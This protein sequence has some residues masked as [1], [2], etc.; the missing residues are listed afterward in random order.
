[1]QQRVQYFCVCEGDQERRY[2]KHLASLLK[3]VTF[4]AVQGRPEKVL[5]TTVSYDRVI[6]FDHD[7]QDGEFRKA[8]EICANEEKRWNSNSK[9]QDFIHCYPAYSNLNFDL[10]LILHSED[11]T[12]AVTDNKAYQKDV[13]R[14]FELHRDADI[15]SEASM[16]KIL[17]RI[18]LMDVKN[19]I[20]RA[21]AIR[22]KKVHGD[23]KRLSGHICYD[24]PD[25]SIHEFLKTVFEECG[26]SL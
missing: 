6:F 7:G 18:T 14:I 25:F 15:K 19:A 20:R 8:F 5:K 3:G 22:G 23:E 17:S 21:E 4:T 10:W 11:F 13:R 24:N 16:N 2:L 1:M 12:K 9:K 26:E